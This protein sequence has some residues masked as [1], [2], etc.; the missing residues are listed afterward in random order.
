M[1]YKAKRVRYAAEKAE[2]RTKL[3]RNVE[4][5]EKHS[6]FEKQHLNGSDKILLDESL[7]SLD[8][9]GDRCGWLLLIFGQAILDNG[10]ECLFCQCNKPQA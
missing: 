6:W 8:P 3:G 10:M 7:Q 5:D 1:V 2:E 9:W 4:T